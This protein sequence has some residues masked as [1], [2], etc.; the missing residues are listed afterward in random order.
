MFK[1]NNSYYLL[2]IA[3]LGGRGGEYCNDATYLGWVVFFKLSTDDGFKK[4]TRIN[5]SN[6]SCLESLNKASSDFVFKSL[7]QG[8]CRHYII[9][10]SL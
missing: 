5:N 7:I 8:H 6:L 9:C 4:N 10:I 3:F 2:K 1:T